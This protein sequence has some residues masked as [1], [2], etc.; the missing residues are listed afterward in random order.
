MFDFPS[1][2]TNELSGW[3]SLNG[4]KSKRFNHPTDLASDVIWVTNVNFSSMNESPIKSLG[5]LRSEGFM[6]TTLSLMLADLDFST[7]DQ[8]RDVAAQKLST[9][10]G[11]Y[12]ALMFK[13]YGGYPH[14]GYNMI[15]NF[16]EMLFEGPKVTEP[17]ILSALDGAY[18]SNTFCIS[19]NRKGNN[20]TIIGVRRN[21]FEH[22]I[23]VM[24]ARVPDGGWSHVSKDFVGKTESERIKTLNSFDLPFIAQIRLEEIDPAVAS[25]FGFGQASFDKKNSTIRKF[26]TNSEF[27]IAQ[28]FAKV[29]I[30]DIFICNSF[31]Q[32]PDD[33]RLPLPIVQDP[34]HALSYSVQLL[35]ETHLLAAMRQSNSPASRHKKR[36]SEIAC[37]LAARDRVITFMMALMLHNAGFQV[38]SYRGGQVFLKVR[39]D[40]CERLSD[41]VLKNG[42]AFP[43]KPAME[44]QFNYQTVDTES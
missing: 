42:W 44:R 8:N 5:N 9:V 40:E 38:S 17:T 11:N 29:S 32:L 30:D 6:P 19:S 14:R 31:R 15:D 39:P 25:I 33:L 3:C 35:C 20:A 4:S 7:N 16:Q 26:I 37:F 23:D 1:L 43:L 12:S 18:Q 10:L 28:Q 22:A 34:V 27:V 2:K 21:R 36:T 13:C 41:T 24:S